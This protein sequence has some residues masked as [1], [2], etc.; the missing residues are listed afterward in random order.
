MAVGGAAVGRQGVGMRVAKVGL[1]D[2]LAAAREQAAL[3]ARGSKAAMAAAAKASDEL[4]CCGHNGFCVLA[5]VHKD[6]DVGE[7]GDEPEAEA[8]D[9]TVV[10]DR[11]KLLNLGG[12][13]SA[14][15]R[16]PA[17]EVISAR[18]EAL[19]QA[20]QALPKTPPP[21]TSAQEGGGKARESLKAAVAAAPRSQAPSTVAS[22]LPRASRETGV[23]GG[24]DAGAGANAQAGSHISF[25]L[26]DDDMAED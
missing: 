18:L 3:K 14:A 16:A 7:E 25:D 15:V 11:G 17:A 8:D 13:K 26:G 22:P 10:V 20:C 21:R 12:G 24:R 9:D 2:K 19:K 1:K 5:L 4:F 23:A 6:E